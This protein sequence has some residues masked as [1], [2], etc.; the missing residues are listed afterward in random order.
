MVFKRSEIRRK[1]E[2]DVNALL[3]AIKYQ[4]LWSF[5]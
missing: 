5:Q 1:Q 3:I 4:G 2:F